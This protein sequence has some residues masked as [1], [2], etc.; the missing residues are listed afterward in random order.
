[1]IFRKKAKAAVAVTPL[2][3]SCEEV[4][5]PNPDCEG[6]IG[7]Q[8]RVAE[9]PGPRTCYSCGLTGWFEGAASR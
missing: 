9:A 3:E 6:T 4:S 2:A 5:C 8:D 7:D 1:M